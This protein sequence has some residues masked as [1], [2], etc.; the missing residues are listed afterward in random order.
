M[1]PDPKAA[2]LIGMA[3][4]VLFIGI[5]VAFASDPGLFSR[6]VIWQGRFASVAALDEG[7]PVYENGL[8]IGRVGDRQ[9]QPQ[10]QDF[11]VELRLDRSWTP[12]NGRSMRIEQT[13]PLRGAY[14][15]AV[16]GSCE[17]MHLPADAPDLREVATCPRLP[18]LFDVANSLLARLYGITQQVQAMVGATAGSGDAQAAQRSRVEQVADNLTAL[19]LSLRT[20][21]DQLGALQPELTR[22][23]VSTRNLTTDADHMVRQTDDMLQHVRRDTLT[24]LDRTLDGTDQIVR[25]NAGTVQ[26]ALG[27]VRYMLGASSGSIVNL[28]MQADAIAANLAELTRQLRDNPGVLLRGRSLADPPGTHAARP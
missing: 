4:L 19:S 27:D 9:W 16:E 22:T 24:R 17:G 15:A 13:N 18:G 25:G 23:L 12:A 21:V 6:R 11:L 5:G 8:I 26:S 1:R 14:V 3:T 10:T 20:L 2:F 7:A 28:A